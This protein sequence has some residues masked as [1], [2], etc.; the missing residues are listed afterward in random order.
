[1]AAKSFNLI[2]PHPTLSPITTTPTQVTLRLLRQEINANAMSIDSTRGGGAHGILALV[3]TVLKYVSYSPNAVFTAPVSPG[4]APIHAAGA[5]APQISEV[6]RQFLVDEREFRLYRHTEAALKKQILQAVSR[7]FTKILCDEE[8]GYASV[9]SLAL[10]NHLEATYGIVTE[11]ELQKS[12]KDLNEAWDVTK[13]I[14][15]VFIRLRKC[16]SFA[17]AHDPITEATAIRA[18]L[19]SFIE[20]GQFTIAIREWMNKAKADRTLD[21]FR[22]HFTLADAERKRLMTTASAGYHHAAAALPAILSALADTPQY[23]CWSHGLGINPKHTSK[24]CNNKAT[25]HRDDATLANLCGGNA[26]IQRIRNEPQ[27]F[28]RNVRPRLAGSSASTVST[29]STAVPPPVPTPA[30]I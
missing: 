18:G 23:Y 29:L 11:A 1:M 13:P 12:A 8:L 28:A 15:D 3:V 25:G 5:T 16:I 27:V 22:D 17:A 21:N 20:S 30:A 7:T 2:F 14:E 24:T 10:M 26:I 9:T 4:I 6:N 19:D